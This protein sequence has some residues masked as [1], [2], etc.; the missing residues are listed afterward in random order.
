ME[1]T[2]A[3][4]AL[5]ITDVSPLHAKFVKSVTKKNK[6]LFDDIRLMKQFCKANRIYGAESYINGFSGYMCELLVINYGGFVKLMKAASKWKTKEI[7]DIM[8]FY[9]GKN[10]MFELNKS[11][12][13]SP[14]ILIDPVQEDR[15]AAAALSE[16]KYSL[17]KKKA[18][19]FIKKPSIHLFEEEELDLE[20]LKKEFVIISFKSLKGKEDVVGAKLVKAFNFVKKELIKEGFEIKKDAWVW[21]RQKQ[22]YFMFKI[23]GDVDKIKVLSGPNISIKDH[24]KFFKKKHKNT[25]VKKGVIYARKKRKIVNGKDYIKFLI[26]QE[27]FKE[28]VKSGEIL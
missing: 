8:N 25:F 3:E 23:G 7:I 18:K 17:F 15:N 1:I 16:E 21:D 24:V 2:K 13:Y 10:I 20:K 27:Y 9:K 28:R 6:K 14:L 22:G 4:S 5:N 11:K 26:A 19:A 12:L